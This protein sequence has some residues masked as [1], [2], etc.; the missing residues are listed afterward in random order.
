MIATDSVA[1]GSLRE[2]TETGAL[3]GLLLLTAEQRPVCPVPCPALIL[4]PCLRVAA[5]WDTACFMR[6]HLRNLESL[7]QVR[8]DLL[9]RH[10]TAACYETGSGLLF[11]RWCLRRWCSCFTTDGR[12]TSNNGFLNICD[13]YST[14]QQIAQQA[15]SVR[16]LSRCGIDMIGSDGT[17]DFNWML[18]PKL[19]AELIML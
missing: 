15:G 11:R 16:T 19:E 9:L 12:R 10:L 7:L 4:L 18:K 5:L 1:S 6:Q 3:S 14:D 17:A 8:S 2:L 13:R